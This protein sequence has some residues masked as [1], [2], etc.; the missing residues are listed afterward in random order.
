VLAFLY[1]KY[2]TN[3]K[4]SLIFLNSSPPSILQQIIAF[5]HGFKRVVI[6]LIASFEQITLQLVQLIFLDAN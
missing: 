6:F 1:L 5:Q 3:K 2:K 4:K